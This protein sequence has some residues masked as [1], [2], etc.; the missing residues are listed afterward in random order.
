MVK[1]VRD[2]DLHSRSWKCYLLMVGDESL[3]D[4]RLLA[5]KD[6]VRCLLWSEVGGW[7]VWR[8]RRSR[9]R[10]KRDVGFSHQL[11]LPWEK[12]SFNPYYRNP[13]QATNMLAFSEKQPKL[14]CLPN[15]V[16]R[17]SLFLTLFNFSKINI[18]SL[19]KCCSLISWNQWSWHFANS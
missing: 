7:S 1:C 6:S 3:Q 15:N 2:K 16:P 19:F 18:K 5:H 12:R 4:F 13:P 17:H 11:L 14:T 9:R 8:D 10:R